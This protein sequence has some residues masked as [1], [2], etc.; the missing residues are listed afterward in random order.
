MMPNII[1]MTGTGTSTPIIPDIFQNPFNIG[2]GLSLQTGGLTTAIV[3]IEHTFD[4]S[5]VMQPSFNGATA[6]MPDGTVSTA[7][8]FQNSGATGGTTAIGTTL[9]VGVETGGLNCNYAFPVAA[10]RVNVASATATS[11]VVAN[12]LQASNAP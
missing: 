9:T 3:A 2:I 5:T 12:F 6:K 7:I 4:Y 10:I 8:W 1:K 11:V